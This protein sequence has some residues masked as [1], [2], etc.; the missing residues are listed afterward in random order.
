ML[1]PMKRELALDPDDLHLLPVELG[2]DLRPPMLGKQLEFATQVDL[3]NHAN[4][5]SRIR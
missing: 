4:S 1:M 3:C 2:D 5:L